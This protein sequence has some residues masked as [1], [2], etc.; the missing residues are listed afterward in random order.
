NP[1]RKEINRADDQGNNPK[2]DYRKLPVQS[3]HNNKSSDQ[4]ND[5]PNDVNESLIVD[6]LNRLRV[7]RHAETGIT[8]PPRVVIFERERLQIRVQ[9]RAQLKQRL[10]PDFHEQIIC[11]P[12]DNSPKKLDTD[13][14]RTEEKNRHVPVGPYRCPCAQKIVN[15][16]LEWPWLEEVQADADKSQGQPEDCLPQEWPVVAENAPIDRHL[17]LGLR[18]A[19]F[20]LN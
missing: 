8:R 18:I 16:D 7:V 11:D 15:D 6:C 5:R 13:Q 12:V 9:I 10:Q 1:M 17:N 4:R 14:R 2:R 19:D 20:R 3:Q